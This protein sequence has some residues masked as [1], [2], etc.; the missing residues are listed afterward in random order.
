M[1][2]IFTT[3]FLL[4]GIAAL[5]ACSTTVVEGAPSSGEPITQAPDGGDAGP[6]VEPPRPPT[7]RQKAQADAITTLV[8]ALAESSAWH[9]RVDANAVKTKERDA[10]LKGDGSD[11]AFFGAVWRSMNAYPQGHQSLYSPDRSVCGKSMAQQQT[12]RFGVCGRPGSGGIAVTFANAGNKLG[13]AKGDVI[14]A[15]GADSGDAMF[16][17]AYLRPVCGGIFP[18]KSGRRHAGAASFFGS[19]PAGTKLTVKNAAG[20]TREV[21]VPSESD[22]KLTDCTDPFARS[23][24]I[25][26]EATVR[27]DGV[28]VIRLPSFYPYDKAFPTNPADFEAFRAAYQAEIV[29]VFDTVKTAPAIVWDAR[30]NT[31]GLTPVGL[32]IVGG[33]PS[34]KAMSISYCK[35]RTPGSAP[36]AFDAEKYAE[37]KITPGG[38]F[39][40]AGKV[41]V[42]TDGL[43][44]SAGDYFP[45]AALKASTVPVVGSSTA[46]A[47]GGGNGPIELAGPP[48]LVANYDPTACFDATTNTP[49]EGNPPAV[50][51]PVEYDAKDLAAGKDTV[52]EAAVKALSLP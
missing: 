13:L 43:G 2:R 36:P 34:A 27:P 49:L 29:K 40:Y 9:E 42:V 39:A 31:G 32:A 41:A 22:A 37:Y 1:L 7:D 30:G 14:V 38:P 23:R 10:V 28:A 52:L 44:Y 24:E 6:E 35:T 48:K 33:F 12:S 16:E 50:R 17:A 26:A 18:A 15:A 47:Y 25:Y 19:V 11:G 20:A 4:A 3:S 45:F 8:D 21:T 5:A 46:G 51:Q